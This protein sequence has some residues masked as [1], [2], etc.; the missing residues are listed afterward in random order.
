MV[1]RLI[2]IGPVQH[3]ISSPNYFVISTE[4]MRSITE[5]RNL[6][7]KDTDFFA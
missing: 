5:W 1:L 3:F 2:G 4:V 6:P 7:L